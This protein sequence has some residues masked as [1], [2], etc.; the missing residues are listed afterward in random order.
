MKQGQKGCYDP[1]CEFH[2]RV[3]DVCTITPGKSSDA[4]QATVQSSQG[5]VTL[6]VERY[7]DI[8]KREVSNALEASA[9]AESNTKAR[10]TVAILHFQGRNIDFCLNKFAYLH[11]PVSHW[12]DWIY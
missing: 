9:K 4:A 2:N 1:G 3:V 7:A 10:P 8:I 12:I 11:V 5:C 6:D